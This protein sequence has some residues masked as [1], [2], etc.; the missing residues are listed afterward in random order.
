MRNRSSYDDSGD[1]LTYAPPA[2]ATSQALTM[3]LI[4]G[5]IG[6]VISIALAFLSVPA[7]NNQVHEQTAGP[8]TYLT[9]GL[10]CLGYIINCVL[11]FVGGFMTGKRIVLRRPAF[12][13]GAIISA[14]IY[15]AGFVERYIPGYPGNVQQQYSDQAAQGILISLLFLV[16]ACLIGGILSQWGAIRATLKHPYYGEEE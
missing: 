1:D 2:N 14:I 5:I 13:T 7:F 10:S 12:L 4:I 3:G 15:I 9:L 16:I 8:F 6:V 11:C